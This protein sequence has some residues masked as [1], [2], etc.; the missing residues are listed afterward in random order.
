MPQFL[1]FALAPNWIKSKSVAK[2]K[3]FQLSCS[4]LWRN[5]WHNGQIYASSNNFNAAPIL[6]FGK[7]KIK[8]NKKTRQN[9]HHIHILGICGTFMA[10]IALIARSDD[11]ADGWAPRTSKF[12]NFAPR[13]RRYSPKCATILFFCY[14]LSLLNPLNLRSIP[15]PV[16]NLWSQNHRPQKQ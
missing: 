7:K 15:E 11:D 6:G 10:G 8:S 5:L 13:L 12:E 4:G 9:M 16:T 3:K 1:F 2:T 14:H